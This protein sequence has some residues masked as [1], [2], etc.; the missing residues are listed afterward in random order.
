MGKKQSLNM[1]ATEAIVA[2]TKALNKARPSNL[3]KMIG[4]DGEAMDEKRFVVTRIS[5]QVKYE[6]FNTDIAYI[7]SQVDLACC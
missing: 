5:P 2:M 6:L 4:M 7:S 3:P 1:E